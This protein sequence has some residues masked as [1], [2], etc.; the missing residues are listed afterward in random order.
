MQLED[1]LTFNMKKIF[2]ILSLFI[3]LSTSAQIDST[4]I[5]QKIIEWNLNPDN[6]GKRVPYFDDNGN[7]VLS[8]IGIAM[9]GL[10]I[11][12]RREV[13]LK[14]NNIYNYKIN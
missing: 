8:M 13:N 12:K 14:F 5:H 7:L 1:D 10:F 3:T 4:E 2:L 9:I 6:I 11:S